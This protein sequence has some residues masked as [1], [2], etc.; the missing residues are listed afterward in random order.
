MK[1]RHYLAV[2]YFSF[3]LIFVFLMLS[4]TESDVMPFL[5]LISICCFGAS[6]LLYVRRRS[7]DER[8]ET[9]S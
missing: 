3:A 8:V 4:F 5:A 2:S 6:T 9:T 7:M 1:A